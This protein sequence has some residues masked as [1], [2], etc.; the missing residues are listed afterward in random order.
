MYNDRASEDPKAK[1]PNS[2]DLLL[3]KDLF[4]RHIFCAR[5][6]EIDT[7]RGS[8]GRYSPLTTYL[9]SKKFSP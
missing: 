2:H 4:C 3:P 7:A 1:P 9:K 6:T 5:L 8:G